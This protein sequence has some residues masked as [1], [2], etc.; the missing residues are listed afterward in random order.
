MINELTKAVLDK[1]GPLHLE[2]DNT[3]RFGLSR[4]NDITQITFWAFS[5][6]SCLIRMLA[7]PKI[8]ENLA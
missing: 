6:G 3:G 7:E 8:K 2:I 1:H 5:L 4:K